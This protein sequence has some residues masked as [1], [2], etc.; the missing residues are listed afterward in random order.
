MTMALS[1]NKSRT[2]RRVDMDCEALLSKIK[3]SQANYGTDSIEN[4]P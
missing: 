3:Q 1:G 2:S 4:I